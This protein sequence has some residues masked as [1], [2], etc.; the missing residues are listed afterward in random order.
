MKIKFVPQ[1]ILIA[2]M[3]L[4]SVIRPPKDY[5]HQHPHK[6]K[7]ESENKLLETNESST[8]TEDKKDK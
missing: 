5:P 6:H 8:K 4:F 1:L 2:L 7:D 3:V